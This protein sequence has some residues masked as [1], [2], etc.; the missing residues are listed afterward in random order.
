MI[1]YFNKKLL[2][3]LTLLILLI[4]SIS[5]VGCS[6]TEDTPLK[7]DVKITITNKVGQPIINTEVSI[8]NM[9][10]ADIAYIYTTDANGQFTIKNLGERELTFIIHSEEKSYTTKYAV[11][12]NELEEGVLTVKF[13]DYE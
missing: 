3:P 11:T 1:R 10:A 9:S 8:T 4:L 2:V 6:E 7:T 12:K 13:N 5:L